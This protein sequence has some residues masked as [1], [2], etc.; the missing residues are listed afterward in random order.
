MLSVD[1]ITAIQS[2]KSNL[3]LDGGGLWIGTLL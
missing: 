1:T 2:P 3:L